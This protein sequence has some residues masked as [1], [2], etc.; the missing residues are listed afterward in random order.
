[1][2]ILQLELYFSFQRTFTFFLLVHLVCVVHVICSFFFACGH[3]VGLWRMFVCFF[4]NYSKYPTFWNEK[5]IFN[6][7]F[8][9]I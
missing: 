4:A 7:V 2:I 5:F 8:L 1:M 6:F 9:K 3:L